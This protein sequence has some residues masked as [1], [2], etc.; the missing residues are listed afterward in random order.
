VTCEAPGPVAL[1]PGVPLTI[2]FHTFYPDG[3]AVCSA[4]NNLSIQQPNSGSASNP[5]G[6]ADRLT[7]G[8]QTALVR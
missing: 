5:A 7:P 1:A 6:N 3:P 8:S 2:P 4:T